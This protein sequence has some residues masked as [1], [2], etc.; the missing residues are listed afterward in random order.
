MEIQQ[1]K[2][3]TIRSYS[4]NLQAEWEQCAN[5]FNSSLQSYLKQSFMHPNPEASKLSES[6]QYSALNGGKRFR[7]VI[8]QFTALFLGLEPTKVIPYALA[9]EMLHSFSLIHDDMPAMDNDDY[10]RGKPSNHK[11]YGEGLALLA[12]DALLNQSYAILAEAYAEQ[13]EIAVKLISCLTKASREMMQGQAIDLKAQQKTPILQDLTEL[14]LLKTGALIRASIEG[15]AIV[16][17]SKLEVT[18]KLKDFGNLLGL[19]FQIKDDLL[20]VLEG[21]D[22]L[23]SY[24]GVLGLDTAKEHLEATNGKA[25]KILDSIS[26]E[27]PILQ[28]LV[29]F[30]YNR[31]N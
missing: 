27:K 9:I 26:S 30:N 10:R 18:E 23:G 11:V 4:L 6:I 2:T 31:S 24:P 28:E 16:A 5:R 3:S 29:F 22:E 7:P 25:L 15:A 12:G 21:K 17:K 1:Q 19:A 14:H 20:E 8:C 13:P